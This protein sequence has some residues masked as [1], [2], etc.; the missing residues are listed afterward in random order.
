[1]AKTKT[2][3][4]MDFKKADEQAKELEEIASA[5]ES[6]ANKDI[7]DCLTAIG[8]H[9]KGDN[10]TAYI[11]KG[12]TVKENIQNVAKS[13]KKSAETIKEIAGNT[14]EAEM[15]ALNSVKTKQ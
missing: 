9:W 12:N 13:L 5:L 2:S 10:A 8:N 7:T 6:L 1:M 4:Q 15:K 14:K 3:I 11:K